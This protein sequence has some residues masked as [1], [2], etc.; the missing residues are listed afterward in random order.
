[1][2]AFISRIKNVKFFFYPNFTIIC[3]MIQFFIIIF[4]ASNFTTTL[5][6]NNLADDLQYMLDKCYYTTCY[7]LLHVYGHPKRE[8]YA[9]ITDT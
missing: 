3:Q 2:V 1:M 5:G 8:S 4:L 9:L 6:H 7:D